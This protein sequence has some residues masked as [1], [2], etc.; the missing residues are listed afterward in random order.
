[1]KTIIAGSRQ[2]EDK[3]ALAQTI[4]DSGFEISEV[5]S[6]TCRG[7]DVMGEDWGRDHD[8]PVKPFPADWLTHGRLAGELRNRNMANYADQ[9]I[10]LW[11]GKSP[12]ASCMLREA[13]KAG[14]KVHTQIY[15]VDMGDLQEL[16]RSIV[17]YMNA[18]KGRIV[19]E[20][21]HWSWEEADEDAPNL[22]DE[23]ISELIREGVMEEQQLTVLKFCA[24]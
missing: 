20:H 9:L 16:E 19:Y 4:A 12:G 7:V 18:G 24:E 10:L 2:I 5:V 21:G 17:D 15:G 3:D 8:V 6:G 14:I 13:N 22:C 23:A 1:M 11:D